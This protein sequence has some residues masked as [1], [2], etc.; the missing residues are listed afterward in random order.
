MSNWK[1]FEDAEDWPNEG[2]LVLFMF[3]GFH[4]ESARFE[5]IAGEP[6]AVMADE[7]SRNDVLAWTEIPE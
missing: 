3:I 7:R 2:Q 1:S 6:V 4:I 5:V